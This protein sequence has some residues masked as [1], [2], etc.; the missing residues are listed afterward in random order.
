MQAYDHS[1]GNSRAAVNRFSCKCTFRRAECTIPRPTGH[2]LENSRDESRFFT[3]ECGHS[4]P[5]AEIQEGPNMYEAFFQLESQPFPAMP[6]VANYFPAQHMEAARQS[7]VRVIERAEGPALVIGPAGVGK[8]LLLR[9]LADHFAHEFRIVMLSGTRITTR[10]S[11]LQ[12]ILFE[13]ELPYRGLDEGELR[14]AFL[15][16]LRR[17]EDLPNGILLLLDEAQ[18]LP[19]RLLDEIRLITNVTHNGTPR[20]RPVVC[21]SP[22]LEEHFASPKLE[23]FNQRIAARCY[24]QPFTREETQEYVRAEVSW[25]GGNPDVLFPEPTVRALFQATDGIPRLINQIGDRALTLTHAL[26]QSQVDPTRIREA[27]AD[28]QQLPPPWEPKHVDV[29]AAQSTVIE[30]GELDDSPSERREAKSV[31]GE[32]DRM[33][34]VAIGDLCVAQNDSPCENPGSACSDF[35]SATVTVQTPYAE[36]SLEWISGGELP[37]VDE[38]VAP[39]IEANPFQETFDED[40]LVIDRLAARSLEDFRG[41]PR[42]TCAESRELARSL[43]QCQSASTPPS[44]CA[45]VESLST[46]LVSDIASPST[47]E[48]STLHE[49]PVIDNSAEFSEIMPAVGNTSPERIELDFEEE[50]ESVPFPWMRR[51]A[52]DDRE[53]ILVEDHASRL[54]H[55]GS[56]VATGGGNPQAPYREL[57]AQLRKV[58]H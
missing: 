40:V 17:N 50:V 8:T 54:R 56:A 39:R 25:A 36:D 12:N 15:D 41:R 47:F 9:V 48:I 11:L 21:G 57:F 23:S 53:I 58:S 55:A 19:L 29:P 28:V 6:D 2:L 32:Y 45:P 46:C 24:L 43:A 16:A 14:L 5:I 51:P 33:S 52:G 3:R 20:V 7:L 13:L 44:P 37:V 30:F 26:G 27:W 34:P 22:R 31:T 4:V 1:V 10:K 42:V 38:P 49:L 35:Q 18:L